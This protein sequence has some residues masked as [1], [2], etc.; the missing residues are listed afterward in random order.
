[1]IR[2]TAAGTATIS[3][4]VAPRLLRELRESRP[5]PADPAQRALLTA[6]EQRVVGL[7]S[8]GVT[9]NEDI[10]RHLCVSVNTV[11]SQTA[12][13]LRKLDLDDRTQLALW[14]AR[15]GLHRRDASSER[16]K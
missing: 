15:N 9:S 10:A 16:M 4:L 13:A 5:A 6:A 2:G 12:A 3:P 11:R 7:L 8:S 1:M 14:G